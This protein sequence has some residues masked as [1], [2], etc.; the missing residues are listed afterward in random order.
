MNKRQ[1]TISHFAYVIKTIRMAI[2]SHITLDLIMIK[3]CPI[4]DLKRN[5][6]ALAFAPQH[7]CLDMPIRHY[8]LVNSIQKLAYRN[9]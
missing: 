6:G 8:R 4:V 5:I 7:L 1:F 3:E 9:G 2:P